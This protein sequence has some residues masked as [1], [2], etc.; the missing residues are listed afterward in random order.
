M[1]VIIKKYLQQFQP[2][3]KAKP[4]LT[5]LDAFDFGN[6]CVQRKSEGADVFGVE[7]CLYL[8]VY[9]PALNLLQN[10]KLPVILYIYGGQFAFGSA[11]YYGPDFLIDEDVV[12]V[13]YISIKYFI[14]IFQICQIHR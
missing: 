7:D 9:V 4:W 12:V 6:D 3:V 2:P 8:N 11:K 5:T 1:C 14:P 10:K 13:S